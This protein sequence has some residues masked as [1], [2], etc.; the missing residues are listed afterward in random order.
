MSIEKDRFEPH[1]EVGERWTLGDA[2]YVE[3]VTDAF[4]AQ[5]GKKA[6]RQDNLAVF[7]ALNFRLESKRVQ[8]AIKRGQEPPTRR[9]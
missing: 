9:V 6:N 7:Y 5:A 1:L 3:R 4:L 2:K 8:S